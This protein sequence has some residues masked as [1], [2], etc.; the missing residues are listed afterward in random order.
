VFLLAQVLVTAVV[1]MPVLGE[2]L[3]TNQVVGGVLVLAGILFVIRG[4][5]R[6]EL[7]LPE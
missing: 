2:F 1:A 5:A 3:R 7:P 6:E 4:T